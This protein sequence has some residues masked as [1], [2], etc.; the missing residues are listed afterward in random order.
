MHYI[1]KANGENAQIS[2]S[3]G[4]WV[5][6]SKN[7]VMFVKEEKDLDSMDRSR[8]VLTTEI[9]RSWFGYYNKLS[10]EQQNQLKQDLEELTL[11]G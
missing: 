6:C 2:Y 11:I 3:N 8:F 1:E 10:A 4:L 5:V 7:R 9:A